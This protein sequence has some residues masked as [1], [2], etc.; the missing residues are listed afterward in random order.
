MHKCVGLTLFIVF[1]L[2]SSDDD[3]LNCNKFRGD[4]ENE[5]EGHG[6]IGKEL[7]GRGQTKNVEVCE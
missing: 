4:K 3:E 5:L 2:S 1:F 6:H 7:Q